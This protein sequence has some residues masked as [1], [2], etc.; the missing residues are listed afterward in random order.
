M[1]A[2]DCITAVM[3]Y[4]H[5]YNTHNMHI[6]TQP[7][8]HICIP[9]HKYT[10]NKREP[11][12]NIHAARGMLHKARCGTLIVGMYALAYGVSVSSCML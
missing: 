12:A 9:I 7:Q 5:Q 11:K 1:G 10:I 3:P 8:K 2:A 4:A 6:K